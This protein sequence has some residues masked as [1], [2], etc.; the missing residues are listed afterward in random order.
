MTCNIFAM[1]ATEKALGESAWTMVLGEQMVG[2]CAF[3]EFICLCSSGQRD[4]QNIVLVFR[5]AREQAQT[6]EE[7]LGNFSDHVRKLEAESLDRTRHVHAARSGFWMESVRR[8]ITVVNGDFPLDLGE[9]HC[10][11]WQCQTCG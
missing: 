7:A 11:L 9:D 6:S 8:G 1:Y 4:A 5:L 2:F 3:S 10:P